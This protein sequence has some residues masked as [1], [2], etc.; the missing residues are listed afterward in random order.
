MFVQSWMGR[1][2]E[3]DPSYLARMAEYY[4]ERGAR[5]ARESAEGR[6]RPVWEIDAEVVEYPLDEEGRTTRAPGW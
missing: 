4:G 5:V 2:E 6:R 1:S 3:I